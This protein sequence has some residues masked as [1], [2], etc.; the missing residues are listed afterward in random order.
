MSSIYNEATGNDSAAA[1]ELRTNAA[2]ARALTQHDPT[3]RLWQKEL[4]N[5]E[6]L[7]ADVR[8]NLGDLPQALNL[9]FAA[10]AD[11]ARLT[12]LDPT[13]LTGIL[14]ESANLINLADTLLRVGRQREAREKLQKALDGLRRMTGRARDAKEFRQKMARGLVGLSQVHLA[15][16]DRTAAL[17]AC[18]EAITTLQPLTRTDARNYETQDLWVRAHICV[19]EGDKVAATKEWLAQIG[20]RQA[21]YLRFLS[22]QQ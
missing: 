2:L 5:V 15:L 20:Y 9:Q 6:A 12:A 22:Q 13:N 21:G 1:D 17:E 19:E 4:L 16:E 10:A 3:N 7:A 8:A 11:L 14:I 18:R